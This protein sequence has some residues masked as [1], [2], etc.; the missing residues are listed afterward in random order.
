MRDVP[1]MVRMLTSMLAE[2]P[3]LRV[4]RIHS[5]GDYLTRE[6]LHAWI[7]VARQHPGITF[8]GYTKVAHWLPSRATLPANMR[9]IVSHGGRFDNVAHGY[10]VAI[11]IPPD[12]M[13]NVPVYTTAESER[14]CMRG[15][16]YALVVHGTQP[17]LDNA[18]DRI[19]V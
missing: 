13:T 6:Y 10:P 16:S 5:S 8:Y 14:A 7:A 12:A 4:L 2:Y 9:L 18:R 15:E 1:A 11:V 19:G 17:A 3:A